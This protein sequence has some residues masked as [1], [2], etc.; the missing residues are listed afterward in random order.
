MF[1]TTLTAENRSGVYDVGYVIDD[2][3]MDQ[4]E[5]AIRALDGKQKT[6]VTLEADDGVPYL[7]IGGGN[8]GKYVVSG[9][10]DDLTYLNLI[11]A[12]AATTS[13]GTAHIVAGGQAAAYPARECVDL[14]LVL[15][16]A[17]TFASNGTFDPALTWEEK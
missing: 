1:V 12:D 2:P 16:A 13:E 11:V 14:E 8:N 7:A 4:V 3:T 9:T 10:E 6:V 15:R 5:S 17:R